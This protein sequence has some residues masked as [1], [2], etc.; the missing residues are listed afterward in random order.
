[1]V[2][3]LCGAFILVAVF[4]SSITGPALAGNKC[5]RDCAMD[6]GCEREVC[7]CLVRENMAR[8][9]IVR[10]KVLVKKFPDRAALVALLARAYL[11]DKNPFWSER[12]LTD[13]LRRHPDDCPTR[14]W[15][16]WVHIGQGDLDLAREVL[17]ESGCPRSEAERG[18]WLLLRAFM[19]HTEGNGDQTSEFVERASGVDELLP[20][21][22]NL[23]LFLRAKTRPGWIEPVALR[24]ELSGGYTSN[25]KA[26][27]PT[28]PGTSGSASGLGRLD[29][30]GRFTWPVHPFVRPVI[31]GGIKGHG[32]SSGQARELSYLEL[33]ARPGLMLGSA[34]PRVFIGYKAD[35]LLLEKEA[36]RYFYEGHR[37]EIEV[38]FG[39]LMLFAG[40]GRRIFKESGRTRWE[41]DGGLGGSAAPLSR[42]RMLL[43]LS[44]RY[45]EAE[46]DPYDQI[47]GTGLLVARVDLGSGLSARLGASVGIDYFPSSGGERGLLAYGTVEKRLD[48]LSKLSAG[49]WSP[50]WRGVRAGLSYEYSWRATTADEADQDYGLRE[51]R[52]LLKMRFTFEANPW[53][54]RALPGGDEIAPDYGVA[55]SSGSG[56]ADERIQDLLRQDE[57]ARRG[58]SCVD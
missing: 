31:E 34:F 42:L 43:A 58:S 3:K 17:D 26:G 51:Q 8:R 50:S 22:E 29:L 44:M 2:R 48:V 15:L 55:G 33:S 56:L 9:A 38:E 25:A 49:I 53:A 27:S 35:L 24:L 20:G 6:I 18:R 30:F 41:F 12:V 40:A 10:L 16:A 1:M 54:P 14:A 4:L 7:D 11:A 23:R 57:S 36:E 19:A 39:N 45:Y 47:G 21:D 13:F 28:D 52:L 32:I 5:E 37:G 46:G